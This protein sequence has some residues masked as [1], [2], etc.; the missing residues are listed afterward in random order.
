MDSGIPKMTGQAEIGEEK[1]L[2]EI[3]CNEQVGW[4]DG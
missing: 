1:G 2:S 4:W 3:E